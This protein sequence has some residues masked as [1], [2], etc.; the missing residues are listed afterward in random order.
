MVLMLWLPQFPG[1]LM[2]LGFGVAALKPVPDVDNTER[3][4]VEPSLKTF[5]LPAL[6]FRLIPSSTSLLTEEP[7]QTGPK[8]T[9]WLKS[10]LR[11]PHP[12]A[13]YLRTPTR[14]RPAS[15]PRL[16][17]ARCAIAARKLASTVGACLSAPSFENPAGSV[18][19]DTLASCPNDKPT[20]RCAAVPYV[21]RPPSVRSCDRRLRSGSRR[22]R[23]TYSG[24][25]P[26]D[27]DPNRRVIGEATDRGC[28][29][30][31][32]ASAS[33][34]SRFVRR[35]RRLASQ[36]LGATRLTGSILDRCERH[37]EQVVGKSREACADRRV[38]VAPAAEPRTVPAP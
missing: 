3:V 19:I 23:R 37:R 31:T 32:D 30:V 20:A 8:L 11:R 36:Q 1:M 24:V 6:P 2:G 29:E 12:Q 35:E 16:A 10:A 21:I 27:R 17:I 13:C 22:P 14:A 26:R 15:G 28:V 34:V 18:R 9:G 38:A 5:V 25:H 33:S 7:T 4:T